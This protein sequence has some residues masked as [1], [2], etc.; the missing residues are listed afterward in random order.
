MKVEKL[1]RLFATI[2]YLKP[3]QIR[4]RL[5]YFLRGKLRKMTRFSYP[6]SKD[7]QSVRLLLTESVPAY[8]SV[9]VEGKKIHFQFLNI[10]V[11]FPRD[12][13]MWNYSKNGKLW[14]YNLNY[15][16]FLMQKEMTR[17]VGLELI[18]HYI[19]NLHKIKDGLEP[20][21]ISLR[22]INWIKFL[23]KFEI[24][25]RK[26][27]DALYAQYYI[28][29]DNLEYQLLGNHLLENG[30]SLLFGAYYFKDSFLYHKATEILYSELEEQI[31][32]DGAHFEL[33]PMY[34]QLML[35]RVLDCLNLV[36]HNDVF[37]RSKLQ[38][39]LESKAERMLGWL[40]TM[41]YENGE[42]PRFN[43]TAKTIA[44]NSFALF[45]YAKE[46]G[47]SHTK[48]SPL[49]ESGYRRYAGDTYQCF[50]DVGNIGP[51]YIP[52]HAHSDTFNFELFVQKFPVIVDTGISTYEDDAVRHFERS[53]R[54]HNTV[55][56]GNEEQSEVWSSFRVARRAHVVSLKEEHMKITAIHDG[57]KKLGLYHLRS[58]EFKK[59][60]IK[61]SDS[62]TGTSRGQYEYFAYFHFH[63]A[64]CDID[65]KDSHI[66]TKF[67]EISFKGSKKIQIDDFMFA[68]GFNKTTKAKMVIV[69]FEEELETRID[70]LP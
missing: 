22:G 50:V 54:A 51:D 65:I 49:S 23:V 10:P 6:F 55:Q 18:H 16:D 17:Q 20:F 64:I 14:T 27:D 28:L 11:E 37:D 35:Y 40:E 34:H 62:I 31:L 60:F 66:F 47:I 39:Y 58:F 25:D 9:G 32:S 70:I 63:P 8:S 13:I 15:F 41:T 57:Y 5:Y 61:I 29:A 12:Q 53:T 2:R 42:V 36:K 69:C 7:S 45:R 24:E 59:D 56:I 26:V 48:K 33:S 19:R 3:I 52:G 38:K 1:Q 4:Y 46:L 30:F 43:D 68:E 67:A 44:P 21:P